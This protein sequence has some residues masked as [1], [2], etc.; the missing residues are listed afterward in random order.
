MK[1]HLIAAAVA[2]TL[3]V[4]AMAQ[5]TISGYLESGI[6]SH[7]RNS[8]EAGAAATAKVKRTQVGTDPFGT[9]NITFAGAEDLGGGL[10]AQFQLTQEFGGDTVDSGNEANDVFE[11]AWVQLSGGFGSVRLGTFSDPA[12]EAGAVH[13]FF[14]DVGRMELR[15][16]SN[17]DNSISYTS[18]KF[19]GFAV[20]LY[21]KQDGKSD[22]NVDGAK[23]QSF[24]L[25]GD[26][27][28]A[29]LGVSHQKYNSDGA[30]NNDDIRQYLSLGYNAGVAQ[31]G[32]G[33]FTL[34]DDSTATDEKT[35]GTSLQ[36]MVPFGA[37]KFGLGYIEYKDDADKT[38][39]MHLMTTYDLSKRTRINFAYESAKT[40]AAN[41][42]GVSGDTDGLS[43]EFLPN[44]TTKG[45]ALSVSHTF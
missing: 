38:K 1:K 43:T 27:G 41:A 29:K 39:T 10:R 31:V 9:N 22:T 15:A 18:P 34:K 13:R 30:D 21:T 3:A 37:F 24:L 8:D 45:M 35:K 23:V 44:A 12:Q 32:L 17:E 14:G 7:E 28:P 2:A 19:S 20:S 36:V 6:T 42:N 33:Y 4:P 16:G 40:G 11:A 5:V 26:V 25:R